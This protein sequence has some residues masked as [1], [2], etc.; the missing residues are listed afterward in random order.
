MFRRSRSIRSMALAGLAG[1]LSATAA[2][3]QVD[4]QQKLTPQNIEN[5]RARIDS[6]T[7]HAGPAA[8]PQNFEMLKLGP[9]FLVSVQ[10]ADDSDFSGN[11]RVDQSGNIDIPQLGK[12]YVAGETAGEARAAIQQR[13]T[14][15]GYLRA[16]LVEVDILEYT[17]PQVTVIGEVAVPGD[18]PLLAPAKLV[19]VLAMAGGTTQL[20][21]NEILITHKGGTGTPIAV[22]YSK[23]TDSAAVDSTRVDPGDTVQ[24][25]SAGVVFVLGAVNRP[26]G[27]L[28]QESGSLSLLQA[29]ALASGTS[30]IASIGRVYVMRKEPNGSVVE[31]QV[32]YH[33]IAEARM[34]DVQLHSHDIVFV[35]TSKFK[36]TFTSTEGIFAAATSASI[37]AAAIY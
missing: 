4:L 26:G 1:L 10:V 21:G 22:P 13:L 3:A 11:F 32:P 15:G 35:P 23:Q 16:P 34:Q 27:Y 24:V 36:A 28:M 9:G 18:Y 14:D 5:S 31:M 19:D 12:L 29:V 33:K 25:K 8:L 37:Y 7:A 20:A 17:S 30:P 2:F 6:L